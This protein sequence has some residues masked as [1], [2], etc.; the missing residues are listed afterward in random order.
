MKVYLAGPINACTDEECRD[1]RNAIKLR[2]PNSIDP[3]RRDYRGREA[4]C[5]REIVELDKREILGADVV[6]VNY[7]KPSTG[8]SMEIFWAWLN[9]IPVIIV[10]APFSTLSPWMIYHSTKI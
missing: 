1:W 8:T 9:S 2:F 3:M 4:Q 10:C 6:L 5:Y 7:V